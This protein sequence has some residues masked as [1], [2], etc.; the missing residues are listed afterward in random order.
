MDRFLG[1]GRQLGACRIFVWDSDQPGSFPD[2][3]SDPDDAGVVSR[4]GVDD[5]LP[6]WS[7]DGEFVA[8][9]ASVTRTPP[10]RDAIFVTAPA[11]EPEFIVR[12]AWLPAGERVTDLAW[13][14]NGRLLLIAVDGDARAL[15]MPERFWAFE[16]A[17]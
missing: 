3:V 10:F 16:A 9:A 2:P 5:Q 4:D 11:R 14:P 1:H 8:Y 13:H 7:P 17:P 12:I 15:V 6:V